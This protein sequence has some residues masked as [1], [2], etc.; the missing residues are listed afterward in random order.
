[1]APDN[2][3]IHIA[4]NITE[5]GTHSSFYFGGAT[6][7]ELYALNSELDVLKADIIERIR[8]APKDYEVEDFGDSGGEEGGK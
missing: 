5:T 2:R 6:V 3:P 4:V 8:D 7:G 1:M